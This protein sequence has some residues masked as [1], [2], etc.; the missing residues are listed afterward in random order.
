MTIHHYISIRMAKISKTENTKCWWR[1]GTVGILEH[2][3]YKSELMQP[4][5][6]QKKLRFQKE[7]YTTLLNKQIECLVMW[8]EKKD[9]YL[10]IE[11][12]LIENTSKW[13]HIWDVKIWKTFLLKFLWEMTI[14][15][16][17]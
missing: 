10:Y 3:R 1:F 4:L 9:K 17:M 7:V 11:I 12:K 2:C 15:S 13:K 6:T 16:T 5:F 8:S 14:F